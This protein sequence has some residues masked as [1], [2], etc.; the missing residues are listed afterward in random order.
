MALWVERVMESL[1]RA[2]DSPRS[3]RFS[4]DFPLMFVDVHRFSSIFRCASRGFVGLRASVFSRNELGHR[5][6]LPDLVL[7]KISAFASCAM[8]K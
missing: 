3:V 1:R 7:A 5:P 8:S 2:S 4:I 6:E